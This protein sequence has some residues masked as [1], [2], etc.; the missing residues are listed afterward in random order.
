[1]RIWTIVFAVIFA[2]VYHM[3]VRRIYSQLSTDPALRASVSSVSA[4]LIKTYTEV[5]AKAPTA[6]SAGTVTSPPDASGKSA[7]S[8]IPQNQQTPTLD[9]QT[10]KLSKSYTKVHDELSALDMNL[11]SVPDDW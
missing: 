4:D 10:A 7:P 5:D 8:A 2:F 11:L 9:E 1:M 3:D 6:A